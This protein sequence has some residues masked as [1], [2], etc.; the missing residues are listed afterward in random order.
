MHIVH[1]FVPVHD[2]LVNLDW[3]SYLVELAPIGGQLK[4][5]LLRGRVSLQPIL[6]NDVGEEPAPS[7]EASQGFEVSL[8][9]GSA[10]FA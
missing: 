2:H 1:E 5:G 7:S 9:D 3:V 8:D 4:L 10:R 6:I